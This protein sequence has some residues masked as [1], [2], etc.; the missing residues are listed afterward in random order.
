MKEYAVIFEK[1]EANWG[2]IVPDL[3]GCVSIGDTRDEVELNI[4]EAIQLYIEHLRD[5]GLPVPE[6]TTEVG[7]I[8]VAS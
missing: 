2:A 6:P 3:P 7:H 5:R 4:R 1:G 8:R